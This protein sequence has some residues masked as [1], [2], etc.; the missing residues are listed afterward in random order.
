MD[1]C[2]R[3]WVRHCLPCQALKTSRQTVRWPVI[4]MPLPN[5]PGEVIS[6]DYFGPLPLTESG[7]KY[8]LFF[9]D[10]FSR[11]ATMYA[12]SE[13]NYIAEGTANI[14][15]YKYMPHW[16][17]PR[18]LLSDNGPHFSGK[19][20]AAVC[21]LLGSHRMFTSPYH[22]RWNR[23]RQ[24]YDGTN[25]VGRHQRKTDRLGL[26]SPFRANELQ[27]LGPHCDRPCTK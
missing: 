24:P 12:V 3:W 15:V 6:W 8:I 7:N 10:R 1:Q 16:G 26:A 14:L 20:S 22:P 2:A 13:S 19:L 23:T 4:S 27:Q 17:V 11:H 25:V 21:T 18:K 9:T 5:G